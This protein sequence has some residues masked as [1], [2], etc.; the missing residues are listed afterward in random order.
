MTPDDILQS[1]CEST[2]FDSRVESTTSDSRVV[3]HKDD[4]RQHP[5]VELCV[6]DIRQSSHESQRQHSTTSDSLAMSHKDDTR[7]HATVELCVDDIRQSSREWS[8]RSRLVLM[9]AQRHRR[10]TSIKPQLAQNIDPM[11]S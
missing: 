3:S 11:L 2:T 8:S 9:L 10:W 6:N 4:T 5:T 7:R 1:S